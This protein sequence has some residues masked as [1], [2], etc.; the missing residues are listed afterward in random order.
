MEA[1]IHFE[2]LKDCDHARII[3]HSL[4]PEAN[5]N[6]KCIGFHGHKVIQCIGPKQFQ[7]GTGRNPKPTSMTFGGGFL[8]MILMQVVFS[9]V[10][11]YVPCAL[12]DDETRRLEEVAIARLH[13]VFPSHVVRSF[14]S[15]PPSRGDDMPT[16]T[17]VV[18][19]EFPAMADFWRQIDISSGMGPLQV[20]LCSDLDT[21]R[22]DETDFHDRCTSCGPCLSIAD[23]LSRIS[24]P[25]SFVL[26]K[27]IDSES[28]VVGTGHMRASND[29]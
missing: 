22:T 8:G 16:K 24:T 11:E 10:N 18:E 14:G 13:D 9:S 27:V 21:Q 12:N 20:V 19:F 26:S 23:C 2:T 15:V 6:A 7:Q 1:W 17:F 29:A 28:F 3:L 25:Q 5:L 4:Q